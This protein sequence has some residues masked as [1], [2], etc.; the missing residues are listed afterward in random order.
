MKILHTGDW[1]LRDSDLGEALKGLDLIS[2]AV[3]N[4]SPDLVV[5]AADIFNLRNVPLDSM[6]AR[7]AMHNIRAWTD[8]V[9][10][11]IVTGTPYHEGLA[12]TAFTDLS[13]SQHNVFVAVSPCQAVLC[14]GILYS[15]EDHPKY[16]PVDAALVS[17]VPTPTKRYWADFMENP[18]SDDD[19]AAAMSPIFAGFGAVA[20]G[21]GCPHILVGHFSV[22]GAAINERQIM[23]GRDIEIGRDQIAL[24]RADVVCLGHI[25][26]AQK[27]EPNIFYC[28]SL[29]RINFGEREDKGFYIHNLFQDGGGL[30]W[31]EFVRSP[32]KGL[33][34]LDFDMVNPTAYDLAGVVN[35]IAGADI[36]VSIRNYADEAEKIDEGAIENFFLDRGA[37]A[38][39]MRIQRVPRENVRSE[40]IL[41]LSG[42]RDKVLEMARVNGEAAPPESV[43]LKADML[44]AESA[45]EVLDLVK[46]G[47]NK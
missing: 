33:V 25:H 24:A 45:D 6:A 16:K 42:L 23:I 21:Y 10:V 29:H 11:A 15:L 5:I 4:E 1:H 26:M 38:V 41:V 37:L 36:L 22:R 47:A 19:L 14:N 13:G 39:T 44:E 43:L 27:I 3:A 8:S 46:G 12:T 18:G 35:R 32:V 28:G 40:N 7:V 9:P 20:E 34:R 2:E 17:F 30:Q 31:S